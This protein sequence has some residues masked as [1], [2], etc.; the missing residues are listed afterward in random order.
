[1]KKQILHFFFFKP[2]KYINIFF[3]LTLMCCSAGQVLS[4]EPNT[5][6]TDDSFDFAEVD[7]ENLL[8]IDVISVSKRKQKINEA[9]AAIS[10]ITA[11][12]IRAAGVTSIP[13]LF[14]RI[15]NMHVLYN[16]PFWSSVG[17]RIMPV[18]ENNHSLLLIDW[19]EMNIETY[20][21]ALFNN[22]PVTLA[23]IDRIE[24][25]RGPGSALY[26]A[27]AFSGVIHIIT[28]KPKK[29]FSA[30]TEVRLGQFNS[31]YTHAQIMGIHN[32]YSYRFSTGTDITDSQSN[33]PR[34]GLK[35]FKANAYFNVKLGEESSLTFN[36][37]YSNSSGTINFSTS[38]INTDDL[39]QSYFQI[40]YNKNNFNFKSFIAAINT[41]GGY[42]DLDLIAYEDP[43]AGYNGY[44][45]S[46]GDEV[47]LGEL[48]YMDLLKDYT[49]Q[50]DVELSYDFKNIKDQ[51]LILGINGRYTIYNSHF[52]NIDRLTEWRLGVFAHHEYYLFDNFTI[53]TG[54]RGDLN[55]TGRN[56]LNPRLTL[57]WS[58]KINHTF[59]LR[60]VQAFRKPSLMNSGF[61]L[62]VLKA[63]NDL[64]NSLNQLYEETPELNPVNQVHEVFN[65]MPG[66][67]DLD[68]EKIYG[69][70]TGYTASFFRNSLKISIESYY[71]F[72]RD[73][74]GLES[75]N[76]FNIP[77]E[78]ESTIDIIEQ[79]VC[80]A[81]YEYTYRNLDKMLD[82]LGSEFSISYLLFKNT[83]FWLNLNYR[84][85]ELT[86]K[87]WPFS[88]KI[89]NSYKLWAEEH[90]KNV[91]SEYL[92]YESFKET[93]NWF[94]N[95][96]IEH[97]VTKGLKFSVMTQYVSDFK[98]NGRGTDSILLT[99]EDEKINA[100]LIVNSFLSYST[101]LFKQKIELGVI[102][103][104]LLDS[105]QREYFGAYKH[106]IDGNIYGQSSSFI[107]NQ[108]N[109]P[110]N[111]INEEIQIT[112]FG[113]EKHRRRIMVFI[114]WLY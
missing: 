84:Q 4:F 15:P 47:I 44:E 17:I 54:L 101:I 94:F 45:T 11:E 31:L 46:D 79:E 70:E 66:N 26:G 104:N 3:V 25:L 67:K 23:D 19:Q 75:V 99:S 51:L 5:S 102:A 85:I 43:D 16:S 90:G 69:F 91:N 55:K 113:A 93:P 36:S 27:N 59:Q 49:R 78:C 103:E 62:K 96:G 2:S 37:G 108:K 73:R 24:I 6:N 32:N 89:S 33:Y 86:S 38:D 114:N 72:L 58:P 13:E 76:K 65:N 95:F 53:S 1:M 60:Y 68:S 98:F 29:K 40:I 28:K 50:W 14:R 63:E 110:Q 18:D 35:V 71:Y 12:Q 80:K 81:I 10:I 57:R 34:L 61:N 52:N 39:D 30:D 106:K 83:N 20:G 112:D 100:V 107:R 109:N 105:N 56:I 64:T 48:A 8:N 7:L 111:I 82:I 97:I 92:Y 74:I 42:T 9:P 21:M 41:G 22:L 88:K 87:R 77:S